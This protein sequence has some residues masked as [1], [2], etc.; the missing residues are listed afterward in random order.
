MVDVKPKEPRPVLDEAARRQIDDL[1]NR[2]IKHVTVLAGEIG[3]R[4]LFRPQ[5]LRAAA[6]YIRQ[7]WTAQGFPVAEEPFEV[8]GQRCVNLIVE[9]P[10]AGRPHEIVLV[11]AHYDSL[12]GTAGAN[13]N[14]TGVAV[15]LELS[16]A[17]KAARPLRTVR[18]V[19][20]VNEE[21]PF[22]HSEQMGSRLHALNARR[23]HEKIVAM[24]SLET[25][26]YYAHG[27]GSQRY[28][29]PF[30]AFYPDRAD[31]LAVVGNLASR[32]LVVEFLRHLM[33]ATD[34]P[35]EGV[36]TFPWIPGVDWSDHWSFWKEGYPAVMLTDTA[37]YRYPEYHSPGDLPGRISQEEFAR[38]AHGII[39]AVRRLAD[40]P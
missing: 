37:L 7:S 35:V 27:A 14:A 12:I 29:F 23:R 26:G 17:L 3:E 9:Q 19:A 16:A 2:L 40:S 39:G 5:G 22:F 25:L 15:L 31:F 36:A 28:P 30:G 10:G 34:F 18:V 38:A 4:N 6:E 13:D 32:P 20:F 24:V 1:G 11:G 8:A 33:A 21:P